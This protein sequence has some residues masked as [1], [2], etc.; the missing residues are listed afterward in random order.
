MLEPENFIEDIIVTIKAKSSLFIDFNITI[1]I[2]K[3]LKLWDKKV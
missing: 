2:Y 3:N 1:F